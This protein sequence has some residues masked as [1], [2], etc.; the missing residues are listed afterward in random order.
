MFDFIKQHLHALKY[1]GMLALSCDDTKL[2]PSMS[3]YYNHTEQCHMLV[4]GIDGPLRVADP[5]NVRE[6]L[7][8]TASKEGTKVIVRSPQ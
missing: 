5:E 8:N 1:P 3:L 2:L 7:E 6:I 4:G